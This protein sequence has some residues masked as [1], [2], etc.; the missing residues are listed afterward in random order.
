MLC[1]LSVKGQALAPEDA[2]KRTTHLATNVYVLVWIWAC[3]REFATQRES[4]NE[5]HVASQAA[6]GM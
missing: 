3:Y 5:Q 1:E 4:G 6:D 2:V